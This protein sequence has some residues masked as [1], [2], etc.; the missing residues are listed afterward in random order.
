MGRRVEQSLDVLSWI[1]IQ[2]QEA[3]GL[4]EREVSE[5]KA[6]L[7]IHS[8]LCLVSGDRVPR[9]EIEFAETTMKHRPE[10]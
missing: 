8:Q 4:S 2:N 1:R 5:E 7:R 10:V 9:D 3:R 6:V